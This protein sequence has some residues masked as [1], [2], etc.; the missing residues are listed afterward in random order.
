MYTTLQ[1]KSAKTY[2]FIIL[3]LLLSMAFA[4]DKFFLYYLFISIML[5]FLVQHY[6]DN[7]LRYRE[8]K[9]LLVLVAFILLLFSNIPP[10]LSIPDTVRG[11]YIIIAV[12]LEF[13]AYAL[14]LLNLILVVKNE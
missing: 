5:I 2:L 8:V 13:F 6:F 12:I 9:T 10:L 3:T 14:I 11:I 4:T 7:T 1:I